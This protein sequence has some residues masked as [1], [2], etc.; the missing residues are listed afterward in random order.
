MRFKSV[1]FVI[2]AFFTF[3]AEAQAQFTQRLNP[4]VQTSENNVCP[5]DEIELT[6]AYTLPSNRSLLFN[7]LNEHVNIASSPDF[8][9]GAS[10][11]F[12]IEFWLNPSAL[13]PGAIVS[14]GD[15]LGNQGFIIGYN[16][17]INVLLG[18]GTTT[19]A[20]AGNN[21]VPTSNWTH[22]AVIVD[23]AAGIVTTYLDG[24]FDNSV[25]L[26]GLGNINS[27]ELLRF[28]A[29]PVGGGVLAGHFNGYIDEVRIWNTARTVAQINTNRVTHISPNSVT[30]L[31]GYWDFNETMAPTMIDCSPTG[32]NGQI[33]NSASLSANAPSLS[34]SFL[35]LWNTGQTGPTVFANPLDTTTFIVTVG[36]CKY[37]SI[38]SITV[39]VIECEPPA[40]D[41]LA[42]VWA[43]NAFSPNGDNK[44]DL[45]EVQAS[46]LTYYEIQIFNRLGDAMFHSR[47]IL[48][49]WDGT[50]QGDFVK[51]GV[52]VY[53]ITYRNL[54][55]E[56]FEKRGYVTVIR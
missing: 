27:S 25:N 6:V 45:F 30:D 34:F 41:G 17:V 23:R 4:Q 19:I 36:Y 40:E 16:G 10:T 46:N 53:L 22:V 20:M 32:A 37:L 1:K 55:G 12:T 9:F 47:N 44:N 51:E 56:E 5:N 18:D 24:L 35:P 28:A 49:P 48:N 50:F 3:Y 26:T 11:S 21:P 14:K 43:P 7:G 42:V 31:I 33:V 52:Y 15:V 29:A 13:S 2:L 38:D 39:N 54:I 8:D